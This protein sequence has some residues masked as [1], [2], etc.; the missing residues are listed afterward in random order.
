MGISKLRG[1]WVT[2]NPHKFEIPTL[3]FP[4]KPPVNPCKHLQCTALTD[5]SSPGP[6]NYCILSLLSF[7]LPSK[8]ILV[9]PQ[10]D[11]QMKISLYVISLNKVS[12]ILSKFIKIFW[13]LE[14]G[15]LTTPWDNLY[16]SNIVLFDLEVI[17]NVVEGGFISFSSIISWE[18][19]KF[20]SLQ[21]YL[22]LQY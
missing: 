19:I 20:V 13:S 7:I 18:R 4:Y 11:V 5:T 6:Q 12:T 3:R 1:L 22:R 17:Q 10:I 16:P 8:F 15:S 9:K 14:F 21:T 2:C